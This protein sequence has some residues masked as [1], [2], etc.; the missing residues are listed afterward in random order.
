MVSPIS[1]V[2]I[3]RPTSIYETLQELRGHPLA[4][5]TVH[6]GEHPVAVGRQENLQH[7]HRDGDGSRC[8]RNTVQVSEE[9][10]GTP[11]QCQP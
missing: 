9:Y 1:Q 10:S 3:K 6:L 5:S 11:L 2:N 8:V 7:P 4:S